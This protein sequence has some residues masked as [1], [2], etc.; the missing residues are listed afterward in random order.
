MFSDSALMSAVFAP[1]QFATS[2][3][4]LV[5]TFYSIKVKVAGLGVFSAIARGTEGR[6]N[7][8][9]SSG[10]TDPLATSCVLWGVV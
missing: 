3:S 4:H 1:F 8:G 9:T 2:L 5:L 10:T 7:G 6:L